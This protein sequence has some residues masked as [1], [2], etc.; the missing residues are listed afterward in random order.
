M[1][2]KPLS[3][4]RSRIGRACATT[5]LD[6]IAL[7]CTPVLATADSKPELARSL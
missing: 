7:P 6:S 3:V 1:S 5:S 2:P 4:A